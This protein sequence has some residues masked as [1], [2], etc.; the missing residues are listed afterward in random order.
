MSQAEVNAG[1]VAKEASISGS[2]VNA[3]EVNADVET[4]VD[5]P[6]NPA[7]EIGDTNPCWFYTVGSLHFITSGFESPG[8]RV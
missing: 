1:R 5:L 2:A 6:R 3:A 8:S 4:V 7:I